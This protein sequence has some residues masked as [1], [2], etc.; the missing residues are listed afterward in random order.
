MTAKNEYKINILDLGG[1]SSLE[2]K[3]NNDILVSEQKENQYFKEYVLEVIAK[4][5]SSLLRGEEIKTNILENQDKSYTL[6]AEID[7]A[8][9]T[10]SISVNSYQN[11][12]D[13]KSTLTP[14]ETE[15]TLTN[16]NQLRANNIM[17]EFNFMVQN[18]TV[19]QLVAQFHKLIK[20]S[21]YEQMDAE[22]FELCYEAYNYIKNNGWASDAKIVAIIK[23]MHNLTVTCND[24]QDEQL[25]SDICERLAADLDE[26]RIQ[27]LERTR[28]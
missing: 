16:L 14:K 17:A 26:L 22:D 5:K 25:V 10:V 11:L 28:K 2:I 21:S 19:N 24:E 3:Y 23:A 7:S 1:A 27:K 18:G 13:I 6:T 20:R 8:T 15:F 4:V 12:E 9:F